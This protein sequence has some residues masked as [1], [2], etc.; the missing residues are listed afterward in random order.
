MSTTY[1]PEISGRDHCYDWPVRFDRSGG[2]IGI[3]QTTDLEHDPIQRVLLSRSQVAALRKFLEPRR[4]NA[5]SKE[6]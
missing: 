3:T 1:S 4:K 6:S 5:M 2:Y